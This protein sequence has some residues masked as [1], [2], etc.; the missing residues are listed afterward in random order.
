MRTI[1]RHDIDVEFSRVRC[2]EYTEDLDESL[3]EENVD[4]RDLHGIQRDS[5]MIAKFRTVDDP[6][7][8]ESE[9]QRYVELASAASLA[10]FVAVEPLSDGYGVDLGGRKITVQESTPDIHH[11]VDNWLTALWLAV[12]CRNEERIQRLATVSVDNVLRVAGPEYDDFMYSWVDALQRYFRNED[13]QQ[14]FVSAIEGTAPERI[15]I[16][17]ES[18]VLRLLY[19]PIE[20]MYRVLDRDEAG[21]NASLASALDLHRAYWSTRDNADDPDGFIA[22][23]PLGVAVLAKQAGLR[24]D[25]RSEYIPEHLLLGDWI[26]VG[27]P[28]SE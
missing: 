16:S 23:A 25:V 14:S 13:V 24:I 11:D 18:I 19:P 28:G 17:S 5:L 20:M 26:S 21:F 3:V 27:E 9:T 10:K 7:V 8:A 2:G 15:R 22:L 6:T 12:V 1:S 4:S